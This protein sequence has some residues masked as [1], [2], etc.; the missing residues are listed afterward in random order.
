MSALEMYLRE[1]AAGR[2]MMHKVRL[3]ALRQYMRMS[4]EE[5]LITAINKVTNPALLRIMVEAGL[6]KTLMKAVLD[7]TEELVRRQT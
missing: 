3:Q 5:E 6:N 2:G 7:R 1:T 4:K